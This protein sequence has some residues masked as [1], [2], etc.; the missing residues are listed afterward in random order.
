MTTPT[1][2][3]SAFPHCRSNDCSHRSLF[4]IS[5]L[6]QQCLLPQEPCLYFPSAAVVSAPAGALSI[7]PHCHSSVRSRRSPVYISPLPQQCPFPQEPCLY[8]PYCHSSVCSR[9]SPVYISPTATVV[10]APAGALSIFPHCRS[11]VRSRRSPVYISPLPQKCLLSQEPCLYF[12][13]LGVSDP[14]GAFSIFPTAAVVSAPAGGSLYVPHCR[15]SVC[16]RRS[17][18]YIS[19][20]PQ[21]C[22][23]PQEP[24]LYFPTAAALSAPAGA[25]SLFPH[26]RSSVYSLL[27]K[28]FSLFRCRSSTRFHRSPIYFPPMPQLCLL[29]QEPTLYLY[30]EQYPL[31]QKPFFTF[32]MLQWCRYYKRSPASLQL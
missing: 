22:L 16:S 7:F 27:Q 18:V 13:R 6:P 14:A 24:C 4:C 31:P 26:C 12:P 25:L 2:A 32:Q 21:H 17:P 11:S 19:P 28:P 30:T 29:P 10:S 1:G 8:F 20:L 5:P 9:R 23:L 15:S 3:F